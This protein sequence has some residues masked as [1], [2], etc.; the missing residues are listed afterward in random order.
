MDGTERSAFDEGSSNAGHEHTDR[1]FGD[2][3]RDLTRNAFGLVRQEI[4]LATTEVSGKISQ[5]GRDSVLLIIGA[6]IA[7]AGLLLILLAIVMALSVYIPVSVSALA[8]GV[9]A[10]SIGLLVVRTGKKRLNNR[11]FIPNKT[12]DSLREDGK[13]M[14]DQLM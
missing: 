6:S 8:V 13:W 5:A 11:D 4:L 12:I 14:Q 3:F 10:L 7:Y 2:L 9:F 1:P